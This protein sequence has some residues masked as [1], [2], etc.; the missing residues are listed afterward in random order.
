MI[1][2]IQKKNTSIKKMHYSDNLLL[3]LCKLELKCGVNFL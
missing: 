1:V 2:F 3:F